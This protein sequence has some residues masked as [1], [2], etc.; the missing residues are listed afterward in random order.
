VTAFGFGLALASID[1]MTALPVAPEP[2]L[3]L[4]DVAPSFAATALGGAAILLCLWPVGVLVRRRLPRGG[5]WRRFF[6][7]LCLAVPVLLVVAALWIWMLYREVVP[8]GFATPHF[9]AVATLG[10]IWIAI[11]IW[12]PLRVS[13]WVIVTLF[14]IAIG[15]GA[16]ALGRPSRLIGQPW[17]EFGASRHPTSRIVLITVD[18]LRAD[19]VSWY[20]SDT[21]A[22]PNL[23]ALA[24]ES[25]VFR[26]ARSTSSWTVPSVASLLTGL[27]AMSHLVGVGGGPL[28]EEI[29]TIAEYLRDAGYFTAA[30]IDNPLLE[31]NLNLLRGFQ[32]YA[33]MTEFWPPV[34]AVGRRL[35]RRLLPV[36]FG[37][38]G[39]E[40]VTGTV[41]EWLRR[42]RERDFF[43]WIHFY[44]PHVPYAPPVRLLPVGT[45]P[46]KIGVSF[47]LQ[48]EVRQGNKLTPEERDWVRQLYLAETRYVDEQIGAIMGTLRELGLYDG[49]LIALT[50]DHGEEFWEHDRY[51]HGHSLYEEVIRVPLMIKLPGSSATGG[52]P[53]AV[54]NRLLMPT[55]LEQAGISGADDCSSPG[56]LSPLWSGGGGLDFGPIA[57]LSNLF[58][59]EKQA[60]QFGDLK[61]IRSDVT[62]REELFDLAADPGETRSLIWTSEELATQGRELLD[63]IEE[64][65]RAVYECYGAV[66]GEAPAP[67]PA[68]LERLK[69]LGYIQ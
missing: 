43:L 17:E 48:N 4:S 65:H 27:P 69:S 37:R 62:G 56:S 32:E 8:F 63:E 64:R 26:N 41:D 12:A 14:V 1:Q 53:D 68:I 49:S 22:T 2:W 21:P 6:P 18:T 47:A 57:L 59:E 13:G 66:T 39:S 61:F 36:G 20:N 16:V 58:Y 3:V 31:P 29:P 46:E 33:Q 25:V 35:L 30:I 19:A 5:R 60:V 9:A 11:S 15:A 28:P 34:E 45:P 50:S 23:D 54:S 38:S 52:V 40:A 55:I 51:E 67:S 24:V 7:R 44:D 10:L 42:N